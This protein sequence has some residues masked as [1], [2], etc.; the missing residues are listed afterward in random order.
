MKPR[1]WL[2]RAAWA[3][4]WASRWFYTAIGMMVATIVIMFTDRSYPEPVLSPDHLW[5]AVI[6]TGAALTVSFVLGACYLWWGLKAIEEG[7]ID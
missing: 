3:D 7:E 2:Q 5:P 1:E 4:R 6:V